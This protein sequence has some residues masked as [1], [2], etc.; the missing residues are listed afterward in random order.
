[1]TPR[2]PRHHHVVSDAPPPSP[3]SLTPYARLCG[4][5]VDMVADTTLSLR[6]SLADMRKEHKGNIAEVEEGEEVNVGH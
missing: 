6:S 5:D 3:F 1:M 4:D 2:P